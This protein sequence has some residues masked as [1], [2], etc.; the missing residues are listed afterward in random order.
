MTTIEI[1]WPHNDREVVSVSVD[2]NEVLV[3][4][5]AEGAVL[6]AEAIGKALN[7]QVIHKEYGDE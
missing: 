5:R 2:G 3:T 7:I 6:A 1:R 4:D